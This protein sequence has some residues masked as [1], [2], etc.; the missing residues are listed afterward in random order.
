MHALHIYIIDNLCYLD[1]FIYLYYAVYELDSNSRIENEKKHCCF[2]ILDTPLGCQLNVSIL[3][4]SNNK[5]QFKADKGRR[6]RRSRSM[7][8]SESSTS[9]PARGLAKRKMPESF[10]KPPLLKTQI[11]SMEQQTSAASRS[12]SQSQ[13]SSRTHFLAASRRRSTQLSES[14]S[15]L[16]R[17]RRRWCHHGPHRIDGP[18]VRAQLRE[19]SFA[20]GSSSSCVKSNVVVCR[21][22]VS[23]CE[24]VFAARVV[25]SIHGGW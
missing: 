20:R 9:S 17:R 10:Y 13:Q 21:P 12:L 25:Q 15:A 6:R 14:T 2:S 18:S 1:T 8:Q 16:R 22:C 4:F 7:Q 19:Q 24:N 23:A 5:S 3:N 11:C